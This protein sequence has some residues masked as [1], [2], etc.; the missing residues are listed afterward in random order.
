MK[1]HLRAHISLITLLIIGGQLVT[2]ALAATI[3][4]CGIAELQVEI[5]KFSFNSATDF[6]D[7]T[8][9]NDGNN[10]NGA[11]LNNWKLGTIDSTLK[12]LTNFPIRTGETYSFK[13]I[14]GLTATT[15]QIV[16]VDD[17]GSIK[18]AVCWRSST[19]TDQEKSDF[20]KLGTEWNGTVGDC[21]SSSGLPK[22][23]IFARS[24]GIDTNTGNDWKIEATLLTPVE[25]P[26]PLAISPSLP[27]AA[28][29][30]IINELLADPEG[31]D[32]GKEWIELK[33]TSDH[34]V[35]LSG[36]QLDDIEGGSK[37]YTFK[38]ETIGSESFLLMSNTI[39]N[40]TLNNTTDAVR[41]I[42]PNG[43]VT[44]QYI[45]TKV[46]TGKSWARIKNGE[47]EIA[48][49]TTPGEE[50]EETT[51][52]DTNSITE[53]DANTTNPE[54]GNQSP[55]DV[56]EVFPNPSGSDS[57][58][59]WIEI[60]NSSG[61]VLNVSGWK[62]KNAAGKTF[63]FPEGTSI[64][65]FGYITISDKTTK[66]QL[67]NTGDQVQLI[68][69][70]NVVQDTI[71]FQ[72][73]PE[74][75]S[76]ANITTIGI[77]DGNTGDA[78]TQNVVSWKNWFIGSAEAQSMKTA[79]ESQ[80][81]WTDMITKGKPNPVYYRIKGV[82]RR[83]LDTENSFDIERNGKVFTVHVDP[84]KIQPDLIQLITKK[85]ETI[86]ITAI[87]KGDTLILES[88]KVINESSQSES[89]SILIPLLISGSIIAAIITGWI[90]KTKF[91]HDRDPSEQSHTPSHKFQE[92]L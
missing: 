30:V 13:D 80:W 41:L 53:P 82:V 91:R 62:I 54:T 46:E 71:E 40:I 45:Y 75:I 63:T 57:G 17:K 55:V 35:S 31:S 34:P 70:D 51:T 12:T 84:K 23:T 15:D 38:D 14:P 44:S 61:T 65:A 19:P 26:T 29:E 3:I 85:G 88:Y 43:A 59:E 4:P 86:E 77:E 73:A 60:R 36:W 24:P 87:Q 9:I 50:N 48:T 78:P 7:I 49:N 22:E 25:T 5:S 76:F 72:N 89:S 81:E 56:S 67:K 83:E 69:A 90:I 21:L 79:Q 18:D 1:K 6:V 27:V 37:P 66:I 20:L 74:N 33:N 92:E 68:D 8:V 47:W 32:D 42:D 16:I 39:T 64:D 52:T 11:V 10:G 28:N 2:P 58:N